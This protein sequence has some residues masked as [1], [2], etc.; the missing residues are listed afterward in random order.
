MA[1]YAYATEYDEFIPTKRMRIAQD[2]QN[3]FWPVDFDPLR[4]TVPASNYY[5]IGMMEPECS[6]DSGGFYEG[7]Y[8]AFE[9][10]LMNQMTFG[11][12]FQNVSTR[13]FPQKVQTMKLYFKLDKIC[14]ELLC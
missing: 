6:I 3:Q 8:S 2:E 9:P 7:F 11:A 14:L 13:P 4:V 5:D 1:D 12:S 10:P